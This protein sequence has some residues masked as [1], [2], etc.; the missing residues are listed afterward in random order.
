MGRGGRY[1][2]GELGFVEKTVDFVWTTAPLT[3]ATNASPSGNEPT[4]V[5]CRPLAPSGPAEARLTAA[6]FG[7]TVPNTARKPFWNGVHLNHTAAFPN[8]P[9]ALCQFPAGT[10]AVGGPPGWNR[11][12]GR[13]AHLED[14]GWAQVGGARACPGGL[15]H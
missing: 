13:P 11:G 4:Q 14:S 15:W 8:T 3:T 5:P 2:H 1:S 6:P 7:G 10:G 12:G 9:L